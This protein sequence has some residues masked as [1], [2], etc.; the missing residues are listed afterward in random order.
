LPPRPVPRNTAVA[1]R[2]ALPTPPNDATIIENDPG[3]S[4]DDSNSESDTEAVE[5]E[6][7]LD[8][9]EEENAPEGNENDINLT[10]LVWSEQPIQPANPLMTRNATPVGVDHM[11]PVFHTPT[12]S[13]AG[14]QIPRCNELKPSELFCIFYNDA[15]M[16]QFVQAT[17]GYASGVGIIYWKDVDAIEMKKFF[18]VLLIF[19]ISCPPE[20]RMAWENSMFRIPVVCELLSRSRFEQI[21]RA[22]HYVDTS[23]MTAVEKNQLAAADPFWQ[24]TPLA[25]EINR[26]SKA[27]YNCRQA[28]SIDEQCVPFKGRHKC[29]CYNPQKPE[30]WHFK[31]FALNDAATG[32]QWNFVMY[33]GKE[34]YTVYG[35]N[36]TATSYPCIKLTEDEVLWFKNYMLYTDN[37]YTSFFLSILMRRRGIHT[38]GTA[39]CNV[40]GSPKDHQFPKT[41][42]G[43]K[44]RGEMKQVSTEIGGA[45]FYYTAWMDKKPVH[46]LSTFAAS[47]DSVQRSSRTAGGAFVRIEVDRPGVVRKYNYGMG[48]TDKIDQL[49]SY[50]RIDLR[51]TK[52]M[53]KFFFH[54]LNMVTVNCH[55]LYKESRGLSRG[56][57]LY[58][59]LPFTEALITELGFSG[60]PVMA[61]NVLNTKPVARRSL[62]T[63]L[64]DVRRLQGFHEIQILR[65]SRTGKNIRKTCIWCN[66]KGIMTM[67]QQCNVPLCTTSD[68]E[69]DSCNYA[70]HHAPCQCA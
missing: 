34:D 60:Q 17:N 70:F 67:C 65:R 50:Y 64:A 23:R 11:A 48:G 10:A 1:A 4:G 14:P 40:K 13:F 8:G 68:P 52:W 57:D 42:R 15:V 49:I 62:E 55:L 25:D 22:W 24:V 16:N 56:D 45:T 5:N 30:K 3:E 6:A 36:V 43:K 37:W 2:P 58:A 27:S 69:R 19:G 44:A 32:Y 18:A 9:V 53:R 54:F 46:I 12:R 47:S 61:A 39:K 28:L 31:I 66:R 20:T 35:Q 7:V 33:R 63:C 59:L 51:T 29:R 41:G 26:V 21:M 38:C